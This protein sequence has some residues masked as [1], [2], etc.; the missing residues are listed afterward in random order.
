MKIIGAMLACFWLLSASLT[1]AQSDADKCHVYVIDVKATEE[2]R[3]KTDFDA[4]M[5]KSKQEQEAIMNRA[6]VGKMYEEFATKVG[7][8]E[9]TTKTYPFP[10]GKQVI[11]AS[12]FYTDESMASAHHQESMLVAISVAAKASDNALSAPDAAIAEISY[13]DNT[14]AVRVKKNVTLDGRLYVVGLECRCKNVESKEKK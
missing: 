10:K 14:D 8:E 11:T 6:G 2:F 7:E 4:F 1:F 9:L 12:I 13:D 5:K 3:E